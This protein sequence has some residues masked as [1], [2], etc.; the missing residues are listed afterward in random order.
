MQRHNYARATA[1]AAL[2]ACACK[3]AAAGPQSLDRSQA[4]ASTRSQ[5]AASTDS[6]QI[7]TN[8][9]QGSADSSQ[10]S[11][12]ARS[13]QPAN[14]TRNT[15]TITGFGLPAAPDLLERA[16]GGS[17]TAIDTK[18][19]GVVSGNSASQVVS[20]ANIIQ[21]GSFADAVGIPVVIQ[22]SGANVLIQNT[23]V[24]NLQLN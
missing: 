12:T 14:A 6:S 8:S 15:A 16:R 23:T 4:A 17:N 5:A 20:G 22:N 3:V 24:I 19:A 18:L 11:A 13:A 7:S 10:D 21:S 9:S 1:V 2:L